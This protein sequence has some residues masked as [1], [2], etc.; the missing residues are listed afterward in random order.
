M[1]Q[2]YKDNVRPENEIEKLSF[3]S[4]S[5]GWAGFSNWIAHTTDSGRTF[6][7]KYIYHGN[8]NYNG[9][10]VNLTFGF[11]IAGVKAFGPDTLI[12]YGHYGYVPA[13]LHSTDHGNTFTLIYQ[14][15]L[16]VQKLYGITDMVFPQNSNI[17]YAVEADRIIKTTDR[18]KTWSAVYTGGNSFFDFVEAVDDNNVFA[19]STDYYSNKLVKTTDGGSTWQQITIPGRDINHA[20]FITA[21]KGWLNMADGSLYYTINGGTTWTLKNDPAITPLY[22]GRMKFVNDSTGYALGGLFYVLKTT[23]SGKVWEVLPRNN[24]FQYLGYGFNDLHV[25]NADQFWAGGGYGFLEITTNGGGTPVPK[26]YFKID[27]AGQWKTRT[28]NLRNYSRTGYQYKWYVNDVLISTGYHASYTHAFSSGKDSVKLVVTNGSLS[29]SI[30]QYQH[31]NVPPIPAI[32]SFSPKTGST[33][34][35]VIITGTNFSNIS[36]VQFGGTSAQSFTL[37]SPTKITAIVGAGSS[38]NVTLTH[39]SGIISSPGFTYFAPTS[40]PPPVITSFSPVTGPI[41][42]TVTITGNNFDPAPANNIVYFGDTRALVSAAGANQLTV[43]VPMGA[44]HKPIF[45]LNNTTHLSAGSFKPFTTTFEDSVAYFTGKSF[46]PAFTTDHTVGDYVKCLTSA[47]MDGDGKTDIVAT[48]S[49]NN[50]EVVVYRNTT[51]NGNFS[52][53][54]RFAVGALSVY[55][56]GKINTYDVDGDGLQDILGSTNNGEVIVYR[57]TSAPGNIS[58][59]APMQIPVSSSSQELTASDI[60]GDGKP[61]LVSVGWSS[62]SYV[63]LLRNTSSP[64]NISFAAP[65]EYPVNPGYTVASGDINNDGKNDLVV[66]G[67]GS[68][69]KVLWFENNSTPGNIS[70]GPR[71]EIDITS[72]GTSGILMLADMDLDDK[73]DIIL[74]VDR[75]Y[76]IGR[77]TGAAGNT[78]FDFSLKTTAAYNDAVIESLSGDSRPDFAGGQGSNRVFDAYLNISTPGSITQLA[79]VTIAGSLSSYAIH[80]ADFNND[81]KQDV[82]IARADFTGHLLTVYKNG[83][84]TPIDFPVCSGMASV[85]ADLTGASYQWQLDDGNGYVDINDNANFSGTQRQLLGFKNIPATWNGYKYR[86]LVDG[87]YSRAF[88]MWNRTFPP[89]DVT[90][91]ASATS[92][93]YGTNVT[94]TASENSG[95]RIS[96]YRWQINGADYYTYTPKFTP[97]FY[98]TNN[99][100]VRVIAALNDDCSNITYDTSN[101]IVMTVTGGPASVTIST[102]AS[103]VCT[104]A[105]VTFTAVPVNGGSNPTYKW[106]VNNFDVGTNSPVF[107]TN[108]L[109]SSSQ[110]HVLMNTSMACA[111][112]TSVTSNTI[113][114]TVQSPVP[115]TVTISS[116]ASS[117]CPGDRV[118]FTASSTN[119][120][121]APQYQWKKNGQQVGTNSRSYDDNTVVNGDVISVELTT[122]SACAGG[123]V[124]AANSM[125]VQLSAVRTPSNTLTGNT[126][127]NKGQATTLVATAVN[128]GSSIEYQWYDST[129][130]HT[131]TYIPSTNK[132]SLLYTALATGDKVRCQAISNAPCLGWINVLSNTLTFTVNIPTAIDPVEMVSGLHIYPNPVTTT[133]VLDP[134]RLSDN[135]KTL[136]ITDVNGKRIITQDISGKTKEEVRLEQLSKGVY[137]AVLRKKNGTAFYYK[138]I[139]L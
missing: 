38:G 33:G 64:G 94:F 46:T 86:C 47:D 7:K 9:Y 116:N 84:G 22:T 117:T 106:R 128:G 135:W 25:L 133:L 14:S 112:P 136:E 15:Q 99:S 8:V 92:I 74:K 137:V 127:V 83:V 35:M 6:E 61:E 21:G 123:D 82:I 91:T 3:Y 39:W 75:D 59:A 71:M 24:K 30:T 56:R 111:Q 85:E 11:G 102:P 16:N 55:A 37:V 132:F 45:V 50:D 32:T 43:S 100:E 79:P 12:V 134:L 90:I 69:Y 110:V 66:S 2:L 138:F 65:V 125:T 10:S 42:T 103:I 87:K 105:Q 113:S 48:V 101:V 78:R 129:Q 18:G 95:K 26:V 41:G 108:S 115:P 19:I 1:R 126:T 27:T 20:F 53:A 49:D 96:L 34:T 17:G 122:Y 54:E 88:R 118:Y 114:L 52:F 62:N 121:S 67:N 119:G 40:S 72:A 93:C 58:F 63:S 5:Q 77:N 97:S 4:P 70:F 80:A 29:D 76:I 104:G 60:D 36:D 98:V 28:V 89:P 139:K 31:F 57:N 131:W 73:L 68:N 124:V 44:S 120:G 107:T 109:T 130:T 81:G 51:V 23:D 13:I